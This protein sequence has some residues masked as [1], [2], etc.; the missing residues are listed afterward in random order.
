MRM[1][2]KLTDPSLLDPSDFL[3]AP[4]VEASD[5]ETFDVMGESTL[6]QTGCYAFR[7]KRGSPPNDAIDRSH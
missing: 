7:Q 3:K 2:S 1:D 4:A 6:K 5:I